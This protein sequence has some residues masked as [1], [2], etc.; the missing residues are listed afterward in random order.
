MNKT[1]LDAYPLIIMPLSFRYFFN[2]LIDTGYNELEL[3][4]V[5][6]EFQLEYPKLFEKWEQESENN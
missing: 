4:N 6:K 2:L 1:I 5:V 3:L